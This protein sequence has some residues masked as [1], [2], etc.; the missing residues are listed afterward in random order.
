MVGRD[1]VM[2]ARLSQSAVRA[3]LGIAGQAVGAGQ[4]AEWRG[5]RGRVCICV[6]LETGCADRRDKRG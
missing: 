6:R 1:A 3:S 5:A 2:H 4:V